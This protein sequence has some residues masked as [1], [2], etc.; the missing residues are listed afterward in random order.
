MSI[1]EQFQI[2]SGGCV[3]LF[4]FAV[5]AGLITLVRLSRRWPRRGG[6]AGPSTHCAA[7]HRV[8]RPAPLVCFTNTKLA[9]QA[10]RPSQL[11]PHLQLPQRIQFYLRT[12][13]TS[14]VSYP[15]EGE[16]YPDETYLLTATVQPGYEHAGPTF[17]LDDNVVRNHVIGW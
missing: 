15:F 9:G 2:E 8:P 10:P 17:L 4:F 11:E 14:R 1:F 16:Q 13:T 6:P 5:L 3:F 12:N 7:V